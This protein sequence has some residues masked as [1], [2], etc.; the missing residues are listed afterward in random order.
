MDVHKICHMITPG[1]DSM[2]AYFYIMERCMTPGMDLELIHVGLSPMYSH[3]EE[4]KLDY[5]KSR[6]WIKHPIRKLNIP[7]VKMFIQED[8]D[9]FIPSRNLLLA[10][11][12]DVS[13]IPDRN[14]SNL[15]S[16]GFNSDDRVYDSS[17]VFC[18]LASSILSPGVSM[19]SLVRHMTKSELLKWF[20][21]KSNTLSKEEKYELI[22]NT[23][24]CYSGEQIEC[25]KCNA[26]F[27]KNVALCEIGITREMNDFNFLHKR[28][29]ILNDETVSDERKRNI[30]QYVSHLV[31]QYDRYVEFSKYIKEI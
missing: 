20:V 11:L 13:A 8:P 15:I 25:L 31:S 2:C 28:L 23:Y 10:T 4:S 5:I 22:D 7:D 17:D 14:Y 6:G 18:E 1:L 29:S 27:R 30:I 12:V 26:C 21:M 24:S 3:I 19:G 16:F 9:A